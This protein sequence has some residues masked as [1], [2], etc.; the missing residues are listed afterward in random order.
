[1]LNKLFKCILYVWLLLALLNKENKK[2]SQLYLKDIH[3]F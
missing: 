3:I 1:M 2:G